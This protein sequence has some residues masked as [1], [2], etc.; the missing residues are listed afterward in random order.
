MVRLV[1]KRFKAIHAQENKK[2]ACE[3]AKAV[4]E[5]LRAMKLKEAAKK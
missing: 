3:K 1:A 4:V 2:A 5:E